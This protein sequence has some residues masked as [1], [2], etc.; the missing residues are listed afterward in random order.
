MKKAILTILA[1]AMIFLL[2][3][4]GSSPAPVQ[5][6]D[7]PQEE[8]RPEYDANPLT[9]GS[10]ATQETTAAAE[11]GDSKYGG[12]VRIIDTGDF[13]EPIGLPWMAIVARAWNTVIFESMVNLNFAGEFLPN[14]A[15]RWEIDMDKKTITFWMRD[16]V[17]FSDGSKVNAEVVKWLFSMWE[18]DGRGNEDMYYED[19]RIIDDYTI[20]VTY[21]NWQNVLLE[22]FMSPAYSLI[23]MENYMKNGREY[24]LE[25]PVGSGPFLFKQYNR[26]SSVIFERNPNYW[27]EGKPYLDGVEYH[28]IT[29]VMT[30]NAALMA[31]ADSPDA[32]SYFGTTNPEQVYT[33]IQAGVDYD[34]STM[35]SVGSFMLVPN[36]VDE[37]NNPFYDL[38]VRNA[39]SYALDRQ[40]LCDAKG[41]GIWR[42]SS[43]MTGPG[44]A[45]NLPDDNPYLAQ[46][47]YDPDKAKALLADAGYPNGFNTKITA[48]AVFQD[49][50]VAIQEMLRQVGINADLDFPDAGRFNEIQLSGWEGLL[51]F[52]WGQVTNTGVSYYIWWHPDG[53]SY[54]SALRP[55]DYEE[56]YYDA[57]RSKAVDTKL[58]GALSEIA[59]RDQV[60]VPVY[61]NFSTLF[62]RNGLKDSGYKEFGSGLWLPYNAYWDR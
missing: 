7:M 18:E 33:L 14:I 4:C 16:D 3:A 58:F 52:N 36:S 57:R 1:A 34:Y 30:Q 55:P 43:Q 44:Y 28:A 35:R 40:S 6:V 62:I 32:I 27:R 9:G 53:T 10:S 38:R 61:Q 29:D 45:G 59:L 15:E 47:T 24:A 41:F 37:A 60:F 51:G 20:E 5:P 49:Q 2:A 56:K 50:L 23:S 8:V 26:G 31:E 25:H 39:V 12:V 21:I 46:A 17:W 54:V 13:N 42:P 22:H 48:T 11:T 19:V